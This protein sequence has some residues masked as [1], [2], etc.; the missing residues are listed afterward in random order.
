MSNSSARF[1]SDCERAVTLHILLVRST[2]CGTCRRCAFTY[3]LSHME[4]DVKRK[5]TQYVA[6]RKAFRRLSHRIKDACRGRAKSTS[7]SG[8]YYYYGRMG[9][10]DVYTARPKRNHA[11]PIYWKREQYERDLYTEPCCEFKHSIGDGK[12]R[13]VDFW[14]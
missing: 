9:D 4:K 11:L 5:E 2:S 10:F 14:E 6:K 13:K 1:T 8:C 7:I 12:V 3:L